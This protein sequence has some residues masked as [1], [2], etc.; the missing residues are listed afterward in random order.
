MSPGTPPT[1][2][3]ATAP[4]VSPATAPQPVVDAHHHLWDPARRR[5]RWLEG[6]GTTGLRRRFD[7]GDLAVA[8]AGTPVTHTVLVQVLP[9]E[10]ET[11]EFLATAA[12]TAGTGGVRIAGV[13]GWVDLTAPDVGERLAD[14]RAGPGGDRLVGI[15]HLVESEPDPAWL[16]RADVLRGL[17]AV[18]D[19]GLVY[20][21]LLGPA[22]LATAPEVVRA[23]P[24]GRFVLDHL[25]KPPIAAGWSTSG[26]AAAR[27]GSWLA[28]VRALASCPEVAVKLSGMVTEADHASWTTADLMPWATAA[29]DAFGADRTMFG[30]DWPVCLLAARYGDVVDAWRRVTDGLGVDAAAAVGGGTARRWYGLA[31]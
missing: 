6:P 26:A 1:V 11:R 2:S 17:R 19:A 7:V 5:H 22:Q 3:P 10:A 30:S 28:G 27:T 31:P 4:T 29:L 24:G 20:D 15:R 21:L 14:L 23:V 12:G 18:A 8:V 25:A 9:D 16:L 13:V